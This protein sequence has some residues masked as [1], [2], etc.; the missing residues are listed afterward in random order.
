MRKKIKGGKMNILFLI[1][2]CVG[3]GVVGQL[4]MKKGMNTI[5][6]IG[7][8]DLFSS[9]IFEILFQQYVFIGIVFYLLAS[10]LWLVILSQ[11]ELSFVY[12]LISIGYIVTA[13]LSKLIFHESLSLFRFLGILL[14]CG[15][16]YMIILKI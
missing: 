6:N 12:P 13:I 14:I 11:E 1:L 15:G 16:V 7:V 2:I 8:K 3:L 4:T 5:G 9:R 10:L